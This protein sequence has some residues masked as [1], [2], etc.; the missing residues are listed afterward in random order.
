MWK[1]A[2]LRGVLLL[3]ATFCFARPAPAARFLQAYTEQDGKLVA[4]T[5]YSSGDREDAATVWR[6]LMNEPKS[7]FGSLVGIG[8]TFFSGR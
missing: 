3:A 6:F 4:H 7:R 1:G 2:R 8:E 5:F